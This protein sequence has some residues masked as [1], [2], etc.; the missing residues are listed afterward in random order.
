[1]YFRNFSFDNKATDNQRR[2]IEAL[3]RKL[4][5]INPPLI[6]FEEVKITDVTDK[7]G[8]YL[9][10]ILPHKSKKE[11]SLCIA[12][13]DEEIVIFFLDAHEH[14]EMYG[15]NDE[16]II[17]AVYF[18][19]QIFS[20][21]FEIH[22][23]YKGNK[24][25]KTRTYIIDSIGEKEILSSCSYLTTALLNPFARVREETERVSFF[26]NDNKSL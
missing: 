26:E 14:F 10:I 7:D 24:V 20:G 25:I 11:F 8:K 4:E 22:T 5:Y 9:K 1:M 12:V 6:A 3:S 19:S 15:K 18:I 2:F 21:K 23:F 13:Y 17:D 16:W